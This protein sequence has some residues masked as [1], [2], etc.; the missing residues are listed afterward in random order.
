MPH[1]S[2]MAA[3]PVLL[4]LAQ[5]AVVAVGFASIFRLFSV[6]NLS[7]ATAVEIAGL[8]FIVDH[9]IAS[10]FFSIL[11][12]VLFYA[13]FDER[14]AIGISSGL[15]YMALVLDMILNCRR[16]VLLTQAGSGP[17][18]PNVFLY[19]FF[20]VTFVVALLC[21]SNL[22]FWRATGPYLVGILWLL[23]NAFIQ[24]LHF[25]YPPPEES[26]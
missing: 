5:V 26:S 16:L 25:V 10:F 18:R 22:V 8:R 4:A 23:A 24:F 12:L 1:G 15:L 14:M 20:P 2:T 19:V 3:E 21:A 9:G 11:P 6:G 7:A 13:L 17:R